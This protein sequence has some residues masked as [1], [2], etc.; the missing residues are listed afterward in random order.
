MEDMRSMNWLI[1]SLFSPAK[2]WFRLS[3]V[4]RGAKADEPAGDLGKG[5]AQQG[6]P[7]ATSRPH[8]PPC[9]ATG[10]SAPLMR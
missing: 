4:A 10:E 2:N 5:R 3:A 9:S 6:S 8:P 1:S 7:G